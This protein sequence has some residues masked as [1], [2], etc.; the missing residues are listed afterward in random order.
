MIDIHSHILY[1]I[2][3]GASS[4]EDSK[5][6]IDSAI[7]NG[8]KGIILTPHYIL[9][10]KYLTN[11]KVKKDVLKKI[12]KYSKID[13]YLGNEIYINDQIDELIKKDEIS[14]LAKSKYLLIELPVYNEYPNLENYLFELKNKGY[15]IIIAHP[16]RYFYFKNDFNKFLKLV[17]EGIYFQGNFMSLYDIYGKSTKKLFLKILKCRGYSF[18]ASDIHIPKQ[19]FYD[20]LSISK[21]KIAKLTDKKYMEDIFYNNPLKI[22]NNEKIEVEIKKKKSIFDKIRGNVWKR[23]V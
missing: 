14:P 11:N 1:G 3:D 10:S 2:D 7:K 8:V 4:F 21:D 17:H 5:L 18:I 13:L 20:K 12:S 19:G 15:K 6:L 9:E 22:I 23:S 16:E